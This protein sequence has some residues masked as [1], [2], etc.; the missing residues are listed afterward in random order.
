[1]RPLA[2]CWDNEIEGKPL[3]YFGRCLPLHLVQFG[4]A[5]RPVG[6]F[7][8]PAEAAFFKLLSARELRSSQRSPLAIPPLARNDSR[9]GCVH[10]SCII[11]RSYFHVCLRT[12]RMERPKR[13]VYPSSTIASAL[14]VG[15]FA[16]LSCGTRG[17]SP[18]RLSAGF[19]KLVVTAP[20]HPHGNVRLSI[21]RKELRSWQLTYPHI[22]FVTVRQEPW[23]TPT[24]ASRH[25]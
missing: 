4:A 22:Q 2:V 25:R 9:G 1:M 12:A 15:G 14:E 21:F 3:T 5:Q 8:Y 17:F 10:T 6:F 24:A 11:L 19:L 20:D 7:H 16:K 23:R 18:H 13:I